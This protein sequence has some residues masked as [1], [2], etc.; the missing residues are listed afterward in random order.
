MQQGL[1]HTSRDARGDLE[2]SGVARGGA[3][4]VAWQ[5]GGIHEKDLGAGGGGEVGGDTEE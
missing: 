3:P 4:G 5:G 2:D 1:H